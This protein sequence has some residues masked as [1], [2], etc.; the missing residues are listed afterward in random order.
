MAEVDSKASHLPANFFSGWF[1][2]LDKR[3]RVLLL[4]G[5]FRIFALIT[6]LLFLLVLILLSSSSVL[7]DSSAARFS[8]LIPWFAGT[9]AVLVAAL[10]YTIWRELLEPLLRLCRWADLMRGVNLDSTVELGESSDFAELASDI[11]ML[12]K[13]ISSALN[14][15]FWH[16]LFQNHREN[17]KY[18]TNR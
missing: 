17:C 10:A 15:F 11:N 9:A 4:S 12:G 5:R 13:M 7:P 8:Q 1:A 3:D 2:R 6:V 14:I 16:F 18:C